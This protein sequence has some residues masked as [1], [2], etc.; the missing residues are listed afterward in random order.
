[1]IFILLVLAFVIMLLILIGS[2]VAGA[3]R[4]IRGREQKPNFKR[5]LKVKAILTLSFLVAGCAS[6]VRDYRDSK[7]KWQRGGIFGESWADAKTAD[8]AAA[9]G[10]QSKALRSFGITATRMLLTA[11]SAF[12]FRKSAF[13]LTVSQAALMIVFGS[14]MWILIKNG[15][16]L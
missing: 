13:G 9:I 12:T 4:K 16:L 2:L 3:V 6:G 15:I 1:M 11:L 8:K 10:W 7:G 14:S 5:G